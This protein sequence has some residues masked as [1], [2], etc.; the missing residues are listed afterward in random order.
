MSFKSRARLRPLQAGFEGSSG[1]PHGPPGVTV[2][3]RRLGAG[4]L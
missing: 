3:D 1:K 4:S 2:K